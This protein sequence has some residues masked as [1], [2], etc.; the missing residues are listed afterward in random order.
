[1][2]ITGHNGQPIEKSS[3]ETRV[4]DTAKTAA[5]APAVLGA[6]AGA[7]AALASDVLQPAKAALQGLPEI[8]QAKVD[9]LREALA[10]G[11]ISFDA[12]RLAQLIQRFH[13]GGGGRGA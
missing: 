12:D 3:G 8:D 9:A 11:E 5:A 6:S 13:G 2:K 7:T 1:M 4:A 10:R